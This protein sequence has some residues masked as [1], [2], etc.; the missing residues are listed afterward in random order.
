MSSSIDTENVSW[1]QCPG[2]S[3]LVSVSWSLCPCLS[4]LVLVP[5][6]IS[7]Q[8]SSDCGPCDWWT[9][10]DYNVLWKQALWWMWTWLVPAELTDLS[11]PFNQLCGLWTDSWAVS[12]M[13]LRTA[14]NSAEW[15]VRKHPEHAD[16]YMKPE[17]DQNTL[18]KTGPDCM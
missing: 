8:I 14:S 18:D 2:L 12:Q 9:S 4:F 6:L 1:S 13:R 16:E 11:V 10:V 15:E 7:V 5:G 17:H 3:V